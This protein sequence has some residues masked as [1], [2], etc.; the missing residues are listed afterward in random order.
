MIINFHE[1]P[2]N[3]KRWLCV[4]CATELGLD[5]L[6]QGYDYKAMDFKLTLEGREIDLGK[7]LDRIDAHI[8]KLEA[9]LE[10]LR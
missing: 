3:I 5:T 4:F 7:V 9:E 8:D 2:K 6:P 10:E 1:Q